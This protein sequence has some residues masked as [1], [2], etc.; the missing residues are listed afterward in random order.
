VVVV[1]IFSGEMPGLKYVTIT[2]LDTKDT[3]NK[4]VKIISEKA[5]FIC[6]N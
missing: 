3:S 6:D 2:M 1:V 4:D 5:P